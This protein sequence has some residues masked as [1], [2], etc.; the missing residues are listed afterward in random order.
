M[1]W[2]KKT[3]AEERSE[4]TEPGPVIHQ[5]QQTTAKYKTVKTARVVRN[6]TAPRYMTIPQAL[7]DLIRNKKR[8]LRTLYRTL[9]QQTKREA[10]KPSN[11][12]EYEMMERY[13]Q[14]GA[15]QLEKL[16]TQD[17]SVWK[18]CRSLCKTRKTLMPPL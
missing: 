16:A 1:F 14:Q 7:K 5:L 18:I 15:D 2:I 8:L 4:N 11:I 17:G 9:D 13:N 6:Y 10:K 3:P 12:I